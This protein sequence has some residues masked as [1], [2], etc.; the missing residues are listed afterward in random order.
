MHIIQINSYYFSSTVHKQFTYY[1]DQKNIEQT[2]F[3]PLKEKK[4]KDLKIKNG[5]FLIV[6][7]FNFIDRLMY[8]SKI[9]KSL[10]YIIKEI[11]DS[12]NKQYTLSHAH[13]LFINGKIAFEIY[14]KFNIPYVVAV[15]ATDIHL[16][17]KYFYY[18]RE[19]GIDILNYSE[20]I[21][22]L[23]NGHKEQLI[24]IINKYS[25]YDKNNNI[26]NKIE[27][28]SNGINHFWHENKNLGIKKNNDKLEIL[29]VGQFIKRKNIYSIL[30][31]FKESLAL[32]KNLRLTLIGEGKEKNNIEKF[33]NKYQLNDSIIL[34]NWLAKEDLLE[35]YKKSDIFI[36]IA[37]RET[38]GLVYI[39][40]LSQ[41]CYLIYSK[42][43]GVDGLIPNNYGKS[44][45]LK[46][47][48]ELIDSFLSYDK[49]KKE[50]VDDIF[51]QKFNWDNIVN[52]Y[53]EDYKIIKGK[54]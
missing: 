8:F 21:Y 51:F 15:R 39:E 53:I 43:E 27:V 16:F 35:Y 10:K 20:K 49:L 2:I 1:L 22:V 45:D 19:I 5:K 34:K 9:K 29:Y 7:C 23:N 31:Y 46:Y 11:E 37:K 52:S 50:N 24:D 14:K 26:I 48:N 3:V 32:N 47:T 28:Q 17:F 42:G 36:N 44:I 6:D 25:K 38:F 54:E 40:A 30:K 13:S 18:L 4:E 41:N 33:I 12:N